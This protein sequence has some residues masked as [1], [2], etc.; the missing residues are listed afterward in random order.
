M[1][2]RLLLLALL[3][4]GQAQAATHAFC[5]RGA[6]GYRM[7][8]VIAYPDA[9][10]GRT[11]TEDDVTRFAIAGWQRDAFLGRWSLEQRTPATS[12]V[13]RFDTRSLSFP[14]GGDQVRGSYQAWNANGQVDDCGDPG[15]GF[16][17]GNVGQD[18]CVDG[19]FRTASTIDPGTPLV[20]T[21]SLSDPCGPLPMSA[22][23]G[24]RRHG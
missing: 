1:R 16:N 21:G 6:D 12:W 18:V 13:L 14:M 15:F 3:A 22:L 7:E 2:T 20:A 8:G 10:E 19:V 17:G 4:A 9:L 23:P 11:V 24:P 5:W